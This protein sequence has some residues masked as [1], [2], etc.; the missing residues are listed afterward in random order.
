[1][2]QRVF[3]PIRAAGTQITELE[4]EKPIEPGA[5]GWVGYAGLLEKGPT[6]ELIMLS[7]PDI[8]KRRVG[9][10]IADGTCPDSILDYFSLAAG[11]GGIFAKRVTD[12]NEVQAQYNLYARRGDLLTPVGNL[13][14]H[15]GGRWGGKLKRYTT[16]LSAVGQVAET[17]LSLGASELPV[18]D[19]DSFEKDEYKGGFIQLGEVGEKKYTIVGNIWV[20][21][22]WEFSVTSD[23]LMATDIGAAP[24]DLQIFITRENEA[25]A[26]SVEVRDGDENPDTEFGLFI[27]VDGALVGAGYPNLSMDPNSSRFWE[28]II[29]NDTANYEVVAE[30]TWTGAITADIRPANH[31]GKILTVTTTVLTAE[32]ADYTNNTTGTPTFV[33]GTTDDKMVSQKLTC[34]FTSATEFG[35]VSDKFGDIGTGTTDTEFDPPGGLGGANKIKWCPPFTIGAD[36]AIVAT[37]T[38]VINYKPF[39]PDELIDGD[40][41]PDKPNEKREKY[42]IT[43]NDHK[44]ITVAD[45]SDLTASGATDD[46]FMVVAPREFEGGR[47]GNADVA[48]TN[49]TQA[50]DVNNSLFNRIEGLNMG[51][52]KFATPGVTATAVQKAGIAYADAKNHQYREEVPSNITTDDAADEQINETI[53]RSNYKKVNFPSFAYVADPEGNGEGKLKLVPLTG[54]IHGREARIANDNLGYHKAEA[55]TNAKLPAILKLTTGDRI[56]NEEFLNPR[57]INVIKKKGGNFIMWGD[58]VPSTDPTWKWA[59]QREQMSYYEHV[60]Q[61]SFDWIIFALNNVASQQRVLSSLTSFF[62]PEW[63]KG[64]LDGATFADAA[65]IKIDSE[66]NTPATKAAGD[67]FADIL[68]TLVDT[69]ERLRLRIGKSGIFE[70]SV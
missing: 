70:A 22:H 11:A 66:N 23:S 65:T 37:E 30:D 53:G 31:Y 6:D 50:W 46:Y 60:L 62:M 14:A 13:K 49:Y 59:H 38:C 27:Y 61:E 64:A 3:G 47:D 7:S 21:D 34:T 16:L 15:N 5:L 9:S 58:R 55:G 69:V 39:V 41:Y 56:L 20:T 54:M 44:T 48:D 2:A 29:N 42:R 68:L 17:V 52:V 43:D 33:L 36:A 26:L 8:A 45:G 1:M 24:T 32:I 51:L 10:Y 63:V 67:M 57:G 18:V 4:G 25:K 12:G 35:V 28:N 40:L 19:E